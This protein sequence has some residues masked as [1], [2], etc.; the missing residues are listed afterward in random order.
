MHRNAELITRFYSAFAKRDAA[1][2]NACYHR[3][4]HFTDPV[5]GDLRGSD[6]CAMWEMLCARGKD[7]SLTFRDVHADDEHGRARWTARYTFSK[8]RRPV[9]NDIAAAFEFRDGLIV[10]HR[11]EFS[12]Y[13]WARQALGPLGWIFGWTGMLQSRVRVDAGSAVADWIT[14][15][16]AASRS[17]TP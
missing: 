10:R 5:F 3:D 13:R 4:V 6:A 15:R 11:D 12:L 2:M 8:T 7:L 1:G 16:S 17:D 9:I 14:A